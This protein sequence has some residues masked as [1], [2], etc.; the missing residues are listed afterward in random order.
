MKN[1]RL[2]A[3]LFSALFVLV[4][5]CKDDTVAP[6]DPSEERT[7]LLAKTWLVDTANP[8]FVTLDGADISGDFQ[9]F[10]LT[11]TTSFTYSTSGGSPTFDIWQP[12]GSWGYATN[13]D[14]SA[15]LNSL[16]LD[17]AQ[18]VD[19]DNVSDTALQLSFDFSLS[20][21]AHGGRFTGVEG[22]YIFKFVAQ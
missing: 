2:F 18:Q 8:P 7:A 20:K 10:T 9:T 13:S 1:I 17:G 12:S 21:A 16:I 14:G 19:I 6:P 22:R 15:N 4:T 5:G 3:L 11:L